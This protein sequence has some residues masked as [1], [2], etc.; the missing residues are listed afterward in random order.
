MPFVQLGQSFRGG[1][2]TPI[3]DDEL[4]NSVGV[5]LTNLPNSGAGC[6]KLLI[7]F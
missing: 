6:M 1:A 2:T 4:D 3:S 5:V 7:T